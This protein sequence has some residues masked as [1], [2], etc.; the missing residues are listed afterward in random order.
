MKKFALPVLLLTALPACAQGWV[1]YA[2]NDA[3][4]LYFDSLRTRKM[5]DTAFVWDLHDLSA[6][7]RDVQGRTFQSALYATEYQ[8]RARKRRVLS[9][10]T[11]SGKMG[12]GDTVSEESQVSAWSEVTPGSIADELFKHICE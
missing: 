2:Q 9:Q 12:S 3:G 1:N 10:S 5:G 6:P 7:A 4:V 11:L 8:C